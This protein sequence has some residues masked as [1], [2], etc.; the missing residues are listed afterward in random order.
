MD[1]SDK[2]PDSINAKMTYLVDD[3]TRAHVFFIEKPRSLYEK[4]T[5]LLGGMPYRESSG[6]YTDV[7]VKV[8]NGREK[9][10]E[11]DKN[12]FTFGKWDTKLTHDDFCKLD[13]DE[14]IKT[15]YYDE[16]KKYATEV[17][18]ASYVDV[19]HHQLRNSKIASKNDNA[20]HGKF[21]SYATAG[22]HTDSSTS[23]SDDAYTYV[24]KIRKYRFQGLQRSF[25]VILRSNSSVWVIS[26]YFG[27]FSKLKPSCISTFGDQSTTKT[28]SKITT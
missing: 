3:K 21:A 7:D 1:N 23:A 2:T 11:M 25:E 26:D 22:I 9:T 27:Y 18:G 19:V 12:S 24:Y 15:K 20:A 13:Q 14:T 28:R 6:K 17:L 16:M 4:I 5:G 10:F 8:E